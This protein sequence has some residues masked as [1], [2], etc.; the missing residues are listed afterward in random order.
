LSDSVAELFHQDGIRYFSKTAHP[1][2]GGYR[3]SS[4]LWRGTSKNKKKRL[5]YNH[6]RT[7]KEDAYRRLHANRVTYSHE[8]IGAGT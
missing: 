4:P 7:T 1:R 5:D 8:Y 6:N 2:M 3:E